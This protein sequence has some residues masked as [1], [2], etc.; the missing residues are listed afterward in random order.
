[1]IDKVA[2][3]FIRVMAE[4]A[5]AERTNPEVADFVRVTMPSGKTGYVRMMDIAS[6]GVSQMCYAKQGDAWKIAGVLGGA[7]Q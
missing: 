1:V 7:E 6:L 2:M 3:T 5:P 4:D